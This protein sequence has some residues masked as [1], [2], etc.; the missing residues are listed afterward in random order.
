MQS[1]V[2]L[3]ELAKF[4]IEA[5]IST[6]ASHNSDKIVPQRPNFDELVFSKGDWDYRDSYCGFFS[7]PGQEVV[8][9]KETPI[10]AM[11]YSGGML[12]KYW[13]DVNF[14]KETFGF[15]KSALGLVKV[16][17]PYRGPKKLKKGDFEYT[18][19]VK[20]DI[21]SFVGHEVINFKG[22]KVFEQDYIGGL[23]VDK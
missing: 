10:W 9:F 2:N 14:A 15:L 17:A 3:S 4:L 16:S 20:G 19:K 18:S 8:S 1:S 23:I 12:S 6:Y 21:T 22:K 11:A 7:A 13:G 5:K